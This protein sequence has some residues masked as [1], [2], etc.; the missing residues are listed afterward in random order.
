M[1][2]IKHNIIHI[3]GVTTMKY[4][5]NIIRILFLMLFIILL[6]NGKMMLWLALFAAS[7]LVALLFGRIY[8]GYIC[9]M[10]TLMIP[11]EWLSKKLKIQTK[12]SPKW[13][14][15]GYF[16]WIS[17]IISI[18]AMLLSKRFLQINLP[19]LPIWL[20]LSLLVT[21]RYKP[22]VF[23]NLICP[24]ASLQKAFGRF[25]LFSERVN[26]DKCIGCK[27]CE[28]VCPSQAV[29]VNTNENKAEIN[30]A[31]CLQCTSCSQACPEDAISYRKN[32]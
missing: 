3:K 14:K 8:C 13:L 10:N 20:F 27:L 26:K 2:I 4:A 6:V 12:K 29:T 17:L 16:T 11:I 25:A 21:L 7:L 23:H 31:L 9:P 24:F 1:P 32:K 30:T 18:A 28:K 5:I 15:N 19:I 22:E